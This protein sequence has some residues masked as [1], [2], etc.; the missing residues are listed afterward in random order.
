MSTHNDPLEVLD[1]IFGQFQQFLFTKELVEA[2]FQP[3][4]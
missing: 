2:L 1:Q 4:L 3:L